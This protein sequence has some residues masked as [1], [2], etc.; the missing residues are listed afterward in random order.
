[1]RKHG[2]VAELFAGCLLPLPTGRLLPW[3]VTPGTCDY[4]PLTFMLEPPS[5]TTT[6]LWIS[7]ELGQPFILPVHFCLS[8]RAGWFRDWATARILPHAAWGD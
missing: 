5:W 4:Q 8:W 3:T 6:Y 7:P 1:M 2:W